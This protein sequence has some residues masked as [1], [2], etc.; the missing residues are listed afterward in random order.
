LAAGYNELN[1][2]TDLIL[3]TT[4]GQTVLPHSLIANLN[5]SVIAIGDCK[6]TV[7]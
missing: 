3:A 6:V 4:Q 5:H 2:N 1:L 7:I